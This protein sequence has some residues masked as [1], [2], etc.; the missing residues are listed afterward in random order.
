MK[1]LIMKHRSVGMSS[2][3]EIQPSDR[4]INFGETVPNITI[5][6]IENWEPSCEYLKDQDSWFI[7]EDIKTLNVHKLEI[8]GVYG[9]NEA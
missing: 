7:P 6:D 9:S 8:K 4:I 5:K 3:I 2:M 1:R